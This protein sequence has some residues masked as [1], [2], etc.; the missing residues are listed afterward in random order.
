MTGM[1]GN[2]WAIENFSPMDAIPTAV[3]LTTYDG[4][5]GDFMAT[6]LQSLIRQI[7]AGQLRVA[8]GRTFGIGDIVGAHRAMETNVAGGKI[9]VLP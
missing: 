1:V 4:G 6:P 2:K 5:P 8:V 7:E 3:A 9:V